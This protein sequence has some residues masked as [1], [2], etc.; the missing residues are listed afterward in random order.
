MAQA[1]LLRGLIE[2]LSGPSGHL[3]PEGRGTQAGKTPKPS[4][5]SPDVAAE[6]DRIKS[7]G[8]VDVAAFCR[9]VFLAGIAL[10]TITIIIPYGVFTRYVLNSAS[11]WP[12]PMAILLMA[13]WPACRM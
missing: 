12:E 5:K 7:L 9:R 13:I 11:S 1:G 4:R 3:S 10:V 8:Q 2:P 6:R